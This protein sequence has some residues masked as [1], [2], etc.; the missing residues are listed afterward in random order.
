MFA[1]PKI[2]TFIGRSNNVTTNGTISKR[3][4]ELVDIV[5]D[6]YIR[7]LHFAFSFHYIELR[8]KN[9]FSIFFSKYRID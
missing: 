3:F 8:K 1:M 7:R 6:E 9:M 2:D 4:A 5:P